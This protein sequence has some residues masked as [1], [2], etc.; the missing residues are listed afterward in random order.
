M[1]GE[2]A[3]TLPGRR[4]LLGVTGGIAAYK[5]AHLVR[6]LTTA[7]AEVQVVMTPA[8]LRFVGADTFAAL[9]RRPVHSDVFEQPESVLHVRL[10][11]EAEAAVV[12]PA[13][14]NVMARLA[15]GLADDLLTSVLLEATCPLVVAPA[16]H[17][18]MWTHP[19]TQ[20]HVETLRSRGAVL[21][22]P[23]EGALA[24][25]DEGPGRMAEAADIA[26]AVA[27]VLAGRRDLAGR[28][29]L[30]TAGPTHEPIDPVRFLGNRS[31]GKMGF[32]VAAEA[33]RRGADVALVTGPVGLPEPAGV[34]LVRVETAEQMAEAVFDRYGWADAVVM[35]AAVADCRPALAA[36]HKLKKEGVARS[37]ILEPTTDI[38]AALGKRKERQVLV[39]FAAETGDYEKEARR[40]LAEKNLDLVVANEVGRPGTGF[41]A[42]TDRAAILAREGADEPLRMWTKQE[43]ARAICD[44]L[45]RLLEGRRAS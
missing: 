5:A 20:E 18:G 41:G 33:A 4:V 38:L 44:R 25:G 28:R 6:L 42:E 23:V 36:D 10:A 22:G 45:I 12:A 35:A 32:A 39:G 40:K 19:S 26:R 29:V 31:T 7:G 2:D 37:L 21:V 17:S 43:L 9:S 13:T 15:L 3:G 24:A 34:D 27:A 1:A 11:I 14:A 16:M 30:V 8:A